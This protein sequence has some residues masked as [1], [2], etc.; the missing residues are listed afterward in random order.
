MRKQSLVGVQPSGCQAL[1]ALPTTRN[2][3]RATRAG[4]MDAWIL[5]L[6]HWENIDC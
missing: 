4:W 1:P 5:T 6:K 2:F 3:L